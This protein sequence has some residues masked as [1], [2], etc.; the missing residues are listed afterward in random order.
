MFIPSREKLSEKVILPREKMNSQCFTLLLNLNSQGAIRHMDFNLSCLTTKMGI[1][2]LN[3]K[4]IHSRKSSNKI[5]LPQQPLQLS[6]ETVSKGANLTQISN[7]LRSQIQFQNPYN[8]KEF[9][10]LT[11]FWTNLLS[12]MKMCLLIAMIS[13]ILKEQIF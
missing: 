3:R 7:I 6:G 10:M 5:F 8:T 9:H 12:E 4:L 11:N 13:I 2:T 1:L